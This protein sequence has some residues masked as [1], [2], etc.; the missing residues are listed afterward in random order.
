ME[1]LYIENEDLMNDVDVL[2]EEKA[3][4]MENLQLKE[5]ISSKQE[6]ETAELEKKE[7]FVNKHRRTEKAKKKKD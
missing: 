4:V 5:K 2:R 1:I 6:Q 7:Q 3:R